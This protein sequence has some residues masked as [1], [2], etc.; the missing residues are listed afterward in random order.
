[1]EQRPTGSAFSSL[2]QDPLYCKAPRSRVDVSFGQ[3]CGDTL[4]N[5]RLK[6]DQTHL[7]RQHNDR[8]LGEPPT[9]RFGDM[10]A[11]RYALLGV[12]PP[13]VKNQRVIFANLG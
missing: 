4:R 12:S 6:T 8:Q 7:A 3:V 9:N 10:N 2:L 11:V 1:M 5:E 13:H